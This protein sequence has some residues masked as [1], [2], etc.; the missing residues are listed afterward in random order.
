MRLRADHN[1][2]KSFLRIV[3]GTNWGFSI[4]NSNEAAKVITISSWC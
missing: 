2:I 4:S 3:C 1:V